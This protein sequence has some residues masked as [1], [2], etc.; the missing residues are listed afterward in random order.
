MGEQRD[1][2]KNSIEKREM[3]EL[4]KL[5]QQPLRAL[6]KMNSKGN[7]I[8]INRVLPER[9]KPSICERI[10]TKLVNLLKWLRLR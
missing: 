3:E 4:E 6:L 5:F 9:S 2:Q 1:Q 7:S 8:R 10:G